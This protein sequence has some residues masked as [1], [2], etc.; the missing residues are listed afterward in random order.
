MEKATD[1]S[2]P[3]K[4]DPTYTKHAA[5]YDGDPDTMAKIARGDIATEDLPGTHGTL[6]D[7]LIT[8]YVKPSGKK[9]MPPF[10]LKKLLHELSFRQ[11]C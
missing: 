5:G 8:D 1:D 2:G 7:G 4:P 9:G 11:P 3:Y 10:A 6:A